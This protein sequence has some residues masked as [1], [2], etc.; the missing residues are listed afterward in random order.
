MNKF[1]V[2]ILGLFFLTSCK[3]EVNENTSS[4]SLI[5]KDTLTIPLE[6]EDY[7]LS[8]FTHVTNIKDTTY[9]LRD[10]Y[11]SNSI[12]VYNWNT[13]Q[14][15]KRHTYEYEGPNG[16]K[17]FGGAAVFP[18][19]LDSFFILSVTGKVFITK[20]EL[21]IY[22]EKAQFEKSNEFV[23]SYGLNPYR[24][25]LSENKVFFF[26]PSDY[27]ISDKKLYLKRPLIASFNLK[28][29]KINKCSIFVPNE[30]DKPCWDPLQGMMSFTKN[31][32]E[33]L[34][35]LFP[36]LNDLFIYDIKKDSVINKIPFKSKYVNEIKPLSRCDYANNE[37]FNKYLKRTA[38][39]Q[40]IVYDKYRDLYYIFVLLPMKQ[41]EIQDGHHNFEEVMP[42]SIIVLDNNYNK[43]TEEK[44]NSKTYQI[45]DY[46]VT[47]E[48][49]WIS[50][51]NVKS[52]NFDENKLSFSLFKLERK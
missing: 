42:F 1:L 44:Y 23:R 22:Q 18:I 3:S 45:K 24:P 37:K 30:Y 47:E 51:N 34:V 40:T 33:E 21:V 46:F 4:Y 16:V 48:G 2:I 50:N 35:T 12:D 36:V 28:T 17:S 25:V 38:K 11:N 49:L 19:S 27:L 6:N 10:N 39:Y 43:L 5:I 32:K 15:I 20:D 26:V 7:Y 52:D 9:L 29:K 8:Y 13:K 31:K 14:K 41:E